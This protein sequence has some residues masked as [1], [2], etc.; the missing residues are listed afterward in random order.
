MIKN[1]LKFVPKGSINDIP[2]L[3]QIMAWRRLGDKPLSE[4]MLVSLPTHI[5]VTRPQWVNMV[6]GLIFIPAWI[7]NY[8]H[9]DD[10]TDY[11][12]MSKLQR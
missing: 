10:I 5:Y 4:P 8:I 7:S 1:S 3:V 6:I 12:Y 2:A 9:W 11:L